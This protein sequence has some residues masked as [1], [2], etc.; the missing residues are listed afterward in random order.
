MI[1]FYIG[2]GKLLITSDITYS[3]SLLSCS[4]IAIEI[5][6]YLNILLIFFVFNFG[7]LLYSYEVLIIA[8]LHLL[9][10]A[11]FYNGNFITNI[12][13]Y[14]SWSVCQLA[15]MSMIKITVKLNFYFNK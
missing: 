11:Y 10:Y 15:K 5:I 12:W 8:L 3:L 6:V 14:K 13:N 7:F 2:T 9:L 1:T 4:L